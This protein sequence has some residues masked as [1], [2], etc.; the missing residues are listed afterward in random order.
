MLPSGKRILASGLG[1]VGSSPLVYETQE[2]P[3]RVFIEDLLSFS[4]LGGFWDFLF[5]K[6]L[7]LC[8]SPNVCP[9]SVAT[10][11]VPPD[12]SLRASISMRT[13]R[14]IVRM[15]LYLES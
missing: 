5:S 1:Y 11:R 15:Y 6:V 12:S 8:P 4:P 10:R 2:R 9:D 13:L 3:H 7:T 14:K